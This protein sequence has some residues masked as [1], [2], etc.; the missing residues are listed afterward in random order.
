MLDRTA[1]FG[2]KQTFLQV[3][4]GKKVATAPYKGLPDRIVSNDYRD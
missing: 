3:F 4:N 1:G 2:Q